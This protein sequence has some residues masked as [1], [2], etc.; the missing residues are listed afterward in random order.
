MKGDQSSNGHIHILWHLQSYTLLAWGFFP[1]R[2]IHND[3][4]Q[5]ERAK[6]KKM[7]VNKRL[8]I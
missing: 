7:A 8:V 1:T 6:L 2:D 3:R 4:L 5:G